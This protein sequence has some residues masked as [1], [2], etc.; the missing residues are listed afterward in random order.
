MTASIWF[1]GCQ[2]TTHGYHEDIHV[3]LILEESNSASALES[4]AGS[5]L[6]YEVEKILSRVAN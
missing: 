5:A 3:P 2:P 4:C 6:K 1:N